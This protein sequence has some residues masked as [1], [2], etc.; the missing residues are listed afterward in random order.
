MSQTQPDT[1]PVAASNLTLTGHALDKA[2]ADVNDLHPGMMVGPYR[3]IRLLGRG[4]MGQVW[5]AEQT[6]P[7]KR[8]VAIK[9]LARTLNDR[10]AEAW[11]LVERQ[12]LA[13]LVHP[14]IAQIYDAGQLPGGAMFFAMEY[15]EG[16]TLD[17]WVSQ[18][19]PDLP[20]LAALFERICTGIQHAHQRGLIHRDLKPANL[21]VR[22]DGQQALPKIIDFGVAVGGVPGQPVKIDQKVTIGTAAYMAPEQSRPTA[23][24]I[25][26]RAD[27]YALGATLANLL[28]D[29]AGL[30]IEVKHALSHV[31]ASITRTG[32]VDPEM[33]TP[34]PALHALRKNIPKELRAIAVKAMAEDREQRYD[35]AAALGA[36]LQRWRLGMPVLAMNGGRTYSVRC[37]VRRYRWASAAAVTA[38]LALVLGVGAALYGLT[39]ARHAQ[40]IAEQRRVQA[41]GLVGVM[42]GDLATKLRPL[43]RLDLL[44]TVGN[45]A[46]RYLTAAAQTDANSAGSVQRASA[47]RTLGEVYV[48]RDQMVKAASAFAQADAALAGADESLEDRTQLLYERG[49]VAYW[50]GYL[51]RVNGDY[52]AAEKQ[53]QRY[54]GYA[55]SLHAQTADTGQGLVE[56]SYAF[57]N[58]GTLAADA[59]RMD[60]A[61]RLYE[62]SVDR[63]RAYL[64][65]YPEDDAV[66]RDLADSLSWI[67]TAF[68]NQRK[69]ARAAEYFAQQLALL[70][71]IRQRRAGEVSWVWD[72]GLALHWLGNIELAMGRASSLAR[73]NG[74]VAGLRTAVVA[75]PSNV[76]WRENELNARIDLAWAKLVM[77]DAAAAVREYVTIEALLSDSAEVLTRER[78][79]RYQIKISVR[80]SAA[81]LWSG[82]TR[83]AS[84]RLGKAA[85]AMPSLPIDWRQSLR[86]R[87]EQSLL[88]LLQGALAEDSAVAERHW[89]AALELVKSEADQGVEEPLQMAAMIA[90]VRGDD[91]KLRDFEQRLAS[92][93]YDSSRAR[94]ILNH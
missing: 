66:I 35:S 81:L 31:A 17:R 29:R 2:P 13:M 72:E 83:A 56:T 77:G 3:L 58:L 26:A 69:P 5:L 62:E 32:A 73:F 87:L 43:G 94:R 41:E 4:G 86:G 75:D 9:M 15:I 80:Q 82:A 16:S 47:L 88:L 49:N 21:L 19:S 92:F 55:Q 74:A 85:G 12:A 23:E 36:D 20:T 38:V 37:F 70:G 50:L 28:C 51:A 84:E 30:E 6:A 11:F 60:D 14:Y 65:D 90:A 34:K 93:G 46:M 24:G 71:D 45:E 25:D 68:A 63:K 59:K 61:I 10:M 64:I 79:D 53:W 48:N 44:E 78:L 27:V 40:A 89:Q 8:E 22:D 57:H 1:I 91:V 39:E 7:L 76:R 52:A 42:L 18:R 33:V 67:G 54:L